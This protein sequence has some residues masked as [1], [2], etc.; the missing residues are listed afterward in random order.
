MLSFI[1]LGL[2]N[3]VF[4]L[5]GYILDYSFTHGLAIAIHSKLGSLTKHFRCYHHKA[6]VFT[7]ITCPIVANTLEGIAIQSLVDLPIDSVTDHSQDMDCDHLLYACEGDD[8]LCLNFS[9]SKYLIMDSYDNLYVAQRWA[10][11]KKIIK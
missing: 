10:I 2:S 4:A 5:Q 3:Q 6:R 8:S 7:I 1:N 11:S 9:F